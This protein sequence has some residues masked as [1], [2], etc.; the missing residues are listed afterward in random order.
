MRKA[1]LGREGFGGSQGMLNRSA[2]DIEFV[3]VD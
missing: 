2:M 1:V 3:W